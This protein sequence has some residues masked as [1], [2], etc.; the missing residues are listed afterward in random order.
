MKIFSL[1]KNIVCISSVWYLEYI[2]CDTDMKNRIL[3]ITTLTF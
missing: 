2:M 1:N 3:K